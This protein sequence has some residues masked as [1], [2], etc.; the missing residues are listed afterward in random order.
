MLEE[1]SDNLEQEVANITIAGA[2]SETELQS[3]NGSEGS[4][5]EVTDENEKNSSADQ[6]PTNR[7]TGQN[8]SSN[9]TQRNTAKGQAPNRNAG[10]AQRSS[11]MKT[12][13]QKG[14]YVKSDDKGH[15]KSDPKKTPDRVTKNEDAASPKSSPHSSL[16]EKSKGKRF[17]FNLRCCLSHASFRQSQEFY[18]ALT[19]NIDP[20][21]KFI[22]QQSRHLK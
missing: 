8:S 17:L 14:T 20:L 21:F 2:S 19:G 1:R 15:T 16:D 12:Q 4:H 22:N 7:S 18:Y 10:H 9:Q 6:S 11:E 3:Q 5:N 13:V